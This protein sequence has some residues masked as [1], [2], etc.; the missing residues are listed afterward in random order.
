MSH[1]FAPLAGCH[2]LAKAKTPDLRLL[3][4]ACRTAGNVRGLLP[5]AGSHLTGTIESR[6]SHLC[7]GR[8]LRTLN[9][10]AL[11][12]ARALLFLGLGCVDLMRF[13]VLLVGQDLL[14]SAVF[15]VEVGVAGCYEGD[16]EVQGCCL[17]GVEGYADQG[18][19]AQ[20]ERG[21]GKIGNSGAL[22]GSDAVSPP[23]RRKFRRWKKC[24]A[25]MDIQTPTVAKPATDTSTEVNGRWC[26]HTADE[27]SQAAEHADA[28][29]K[30]RD[31]APR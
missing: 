3:P 2:P 29:G 5:F 9:S 14:P 26:H 8:F 27:R 25:V 13:W 11:P 31:A 23:E 19:D 16:S 6:P 1:P 28:Q 18:N 10:P 22:Y 17:G 4:R 21:Y 20:H 7:R 12:L 30:Q 24:A 15:E